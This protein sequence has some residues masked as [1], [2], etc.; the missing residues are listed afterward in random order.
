M[1]QVTIDY[2]AEPTVAR[3][4]HSRAFVRLLLGPIGSGKSVGGIQEIMRIAMLQH[5]QHDRVRRS[6]FAVIRNTYPELKTTTIKTYEDWF[7]PITKMKW[8]VPISG[9][10]R[11]EA[12][13]IKVESEVFFLAMDKPKD[14]KKLLSLELTGAFINECREVPLSVIDMCTGRVGR[15]PAK[16]DGGPV[17][18]CVWMDTNPPDDDHW[19]YTKFEEEHP[20]GWQIF[21]QPPALLKTTVGEETIYIP[22]PEAENVKH[23][24]LGFDYWLRQIPG[25]KP[26]WI[27]VYVLGLY[28]SSAEGRPC[29]P[30]FNEAFHVSD[31]PLLPIHHQPLILGFDFGRTP[32]CIVGQLTPLGQLLV[33]DEIV[34]DAEGQG[35][36]LRKFLAEH[37]RPYMHM[38]YPN[39]SFLVSGDPAGIGRS[40][41]EEEN[42]FDILAE[43]GFPGE[44]ATTNEIDMRIETVEYFLNRSIGGEPGLLVDPKC[45]VLRKG[46][47]GGYQFERVQLAGDIRFKDRPVKNRYS[48]PHDAFQYLADLAKHGG[49]FS[50][51]Y[52]ARQVSAGANPSGWT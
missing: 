51:K 20:K 48:H 49:G 47:T 1:S 29:Y 42:A 32:A 23:Q 36:G 27:K 26:E 25:K 19:I 45:K 39:M 46:F 8:D 34:V 21:K 3:F 37:V 7:G 31:K 4:H 17:Q 44:P 50:S 16:K 14:I 12:G 33:L 28:G 15:Y 5:P 30:T 43:E 52:R 40:Q 13:N 22:N 10:L 2:V 6:R 9:M 24:P 35:M 41:Y 38:Q 18:S 11:F